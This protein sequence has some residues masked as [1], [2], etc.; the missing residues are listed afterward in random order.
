MVKKPIHKF[1]IFKSDA[2]PFFFYIDIFP[3][4]PSN[5]K[6]R[7]VHHLLEAININPIMPLPMRVDRVYNGEKSVLIR[8]REPISSSI[9]DDLIATINPSMFLQYGME[10]LLF[11]TE[12][13]AF[14]SYFKSLTLERAQKWWDSTKFLYVKLSR[15]EEDFSS[16]NKAY[17][18]TVLKAKLNNE[19]LINAA[20]NYCKM[21]QEICEERINKNTI[22]IQTRKRETQGNLY[23]KKVVKYVK[24]GKKAEDVQYHPEL[25]DLDVYDLSEIGFKIKLDELHSVINELKPHSIKYIPI[26]FYDDLLEC[27]LQNLKILEDGKANML[28]PSILIDQNIIT[29]H[30][31]T[32]VDNTKIQNY[33]WFSTFDEIRLEEIVKLIQNRKLQFSKLYIK[34]RNS[35]SW[36]EKI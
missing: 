8:P 35:I 14:E 26:L 18:H 36:K 10:K 1:K 6:S 27:M 31:T 4:D 11:F 7:Y 16:F 24:K 9:M 3:P 34:K 28:D 23:Q 20:T 12:I 21:I 22:L 29:L 17:L 15:L 2:A 25:I 32:E 30:K 19:D 33:S 5:F 13:R